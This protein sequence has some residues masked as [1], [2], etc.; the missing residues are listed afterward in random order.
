MIS[1]RFPDSPPFSGWGWYEE[2]VESH[3]ELLR[4]LGSIIH[5]GRQYIESLKVGE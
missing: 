1:G 5:K 2:L 4:R 3:G